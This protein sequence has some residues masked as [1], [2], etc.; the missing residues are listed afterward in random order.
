MVKII[1]INTDG[2]S[3][4]TEAFEGSTIM[5]NA[6]ENMINGIDAECGGSCSCATCHVYIDEKW[7]DKIEKPN[8]IEEDMLNFV[9]D[10]KYNSRLSCQIKISKK[11]EGLIVYIPK[12]QS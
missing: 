5:E 8:S 2:T 11:L 9:Y 12:N 6:T 3:I 1:Y 4:V 10:F 7:L